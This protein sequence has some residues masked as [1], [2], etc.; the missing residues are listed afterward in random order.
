M[1]DHDILF[2]PGAGGS[3]KFWEPVA[4][5]LPSDWNKVSFGWPGLGDE[6]HDPAINSIDDLVKLV[7]TR[8]DGPVDLVAQSMGGVVAV[9]VA[10]SRPE[11]V[12][13]LVLVATSGGVDMARFGAADWR[14]DY[15]KL[16][17]TAAG[18]ILQERA[19]APLPVENISA[20]TLLIW[21]DEDP[22]SPVA[23][24]RELEHRIPDA[25]LCIVS[26]GDHDLALT[27]SDAVANLIA[28]HL[29]G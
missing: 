10:L 18:W 29:G 11:I 24:G 5:R 14:S 7:E 12:R 3:E 19:A 17:P 27:R 28:E 2:L 15:R 21:G 25:K 16:F 4:Q 26:G 6:P 9:R 13:R 22:I 23:V 8:I 20:P 1:K